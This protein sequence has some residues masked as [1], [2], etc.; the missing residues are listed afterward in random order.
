[1]RGG[2]VVVCRAVVCRVVVCALTRA[3][4]QEIRPMAT[5]IQRWSTDRRLDR[6]L[7][8]VK[9]IMRSPPF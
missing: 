2:F 6:V 5:A 7:I 9:V 3:T 1:M 4:K 8:L